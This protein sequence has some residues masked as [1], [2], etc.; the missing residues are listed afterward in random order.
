LNPNHESYRL[1]VMACRVAQDAQ[2][3]EDTMNYIKACGQPLNCPIYTEVI[4]AYLQNHKPL[5]AMEL[6]DEMMQVD[7]LHP[8]TN[9]YN[10]MMG[11]Y[12]QTR[13]CNGAIDM[14]REMEERG[15]KITRVTYNAALGAVA[16]GDEEDGYLAK[17]FTL[18]DEM[19]QK[20]IPPNARTFS[21][22]II[23]CGRFGDLEAATKV[24]TLMDKMQVAR[25]ELIYTSYLQAI[26]GS[27]QKQPDICWMGDAEPLS[28]AARLEMA[29]GVLVKMKDEGLR[30]PIKTANALL[31][32][33]CSALDKRKSLLFMES[34]PRRFQLVPDI[35]S[36]MRVW[37]VLDKTDSYTEAK[38]IFDEMYR[39][40]IKQKRS[41]YV[42]LLRLACANRDPKGC[43][44]YLKLMKMNGHVVR[45]HDQAWLAM[46]SGTEAEQLHARR[47]FAK[48][49]VRIRKLQRVKLMNH[50]AG[51]KESSWTPPSTK[52]G[53]FRR[54]LE[55]AGVHPP[56]DLPGRRTV[57]R[58]FWEH[59]D[60]TVGGLDDPW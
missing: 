17:V 56:K 53:E 49:R 12:R 55:W 18:F 31:N 35:H 30:I 28:I 48:D 41:M 5:K 19:I 6:L 57:G 26:A 37:N 45:D 58:I 38:L 15:F 10:R 29:E 46:C 9:L 51:G 23:A 1:L 44:H 7:G 11:F 2:R 24:L 52:G 4:R 32:C 25:N 50:L 21:A 59:G 34:M 20:E 8:D 39:M 40:G 13:N 3:A 60:R 16:M 33:Y 22:L 14:M 47:R 36:Y 43:E 42:T 54:M 27:I